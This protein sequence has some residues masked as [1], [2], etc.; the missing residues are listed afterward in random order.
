MRI[1]SINDERTYAKAVE[2][3]QELVSTTA[4]G[5]PDWNEYV[6]L[7]RLVERYEDE[8]LVYLEP[9]VSMK[10]THNIDIAK[11]LRHDHIKDED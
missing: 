3:M 2:R 5:K 1:T 10:S 9:V 7:S 8:H 11:K 6:E 4:P